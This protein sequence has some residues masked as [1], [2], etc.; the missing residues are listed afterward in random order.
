M[1]RR[2]EDVGVAKLTAP[3]L[4]TLTLA[5][6]AGAFI[7]FG[8]MLSTV[9]MSGAQDVI[10]YGPSRV[11]GGLVFSLGLVLV[12][13]GGAELF[14]GNTLIVMAVV[15]RRTRTVTMLKNWTVVYAGNLIGAMLTAWAVYASGQY[16][17]GESAVGRQALAVADAK[18]ALSIDD[19]LVRGVLA[20]V[21]VCLAVWLCLA[22]RTVADKILAIVFPI[23]AFVAAGFEHSVANMYLL[24]AAILVRDGA[25]AGFWATASTSASAYPHVTW[26]DFAGNLVAVTI[27]NVIGGAVLVGAV[28][29]LVYRT[30]GN[31]SER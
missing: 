20:N 7:G 12:V 16:W 26:L 13:V 11:L 31:G 28:Y 29:A 19:A 23:T 6:L 10:G 4:Q 27:G 22:A 1:A 21:L 18:G 24:P 2:A 15:A 9:A 17:N 5:V 14:T 3:P 25:P 8:A 30:Q